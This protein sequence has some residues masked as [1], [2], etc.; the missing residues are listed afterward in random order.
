V[1]LEPGNGII[2]RT[3]LAEP[4]ELRLILDGN[5]MPLTAAVGRAH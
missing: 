5:Q 2:M 1:T 4:E 3:S